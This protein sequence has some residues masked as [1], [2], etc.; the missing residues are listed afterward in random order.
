MKI[1]SEVPVK[2]WIGC[3]KREC[4]STFPFFTGYRIQG[5]GWH[6]FGVKGYR[7][8]GEGWHTFGVKGYRIQGG[9]WHTFGVKGYRIEGE[10]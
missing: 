7:I 1:L 6:T 8:E 10:G 2:M 9:G 4:H 3:K 5:G